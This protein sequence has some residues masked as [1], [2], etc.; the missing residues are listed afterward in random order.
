MLPALGIRLQDL[1]NTA[2]SRIE[3]KIIMS[4]KW[5]SKDATVV[6]LVLISFTRRS[7]IE[8]LNGVIAFMANSYNFGQFTAND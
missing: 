5:K 6:E 8:G 3:K 2:R 7:I 1:Q 4:T